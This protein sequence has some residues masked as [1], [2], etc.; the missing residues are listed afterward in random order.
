M[1]EWHISPVT[2]AETWTDELLLVMI[3]NLIDRKEQYDK[4]KEAKVSDTE[5]FRAMGKQVQV[6]NGNKSG[7]RPGSIRARQKQT[8]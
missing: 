6:K 3:D 8:R 5:L 7:R 4:P 2:I 1:A